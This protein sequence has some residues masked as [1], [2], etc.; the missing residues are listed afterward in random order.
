MSQDLSLV[1]NHAFQLARTLMVPVTLFRSGDEF[2]VL[3]SAELDDD[4]VETLAEYDPF[5]QGPAH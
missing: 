3:P 1:Q 4:E 2:G 5:E